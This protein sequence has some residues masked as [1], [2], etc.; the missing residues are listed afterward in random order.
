MS[1]SVNFLVF[2]T[3]NTTYV[4]QT[5]SNDTVLEAQRLTGLGGLLGRFDHRHHDPTAFRADS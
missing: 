2:L 4:Y 1:H 3:I 5:S